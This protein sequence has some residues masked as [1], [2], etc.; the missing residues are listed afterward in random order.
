M[1]AIIFIIILLFFYYYFYFVSISATELI[2]LQL[3]IHEGIVL[4]FWVKLAAKV[5]K[6]L[7]R[8]AVVEYYSRLSRCHW[9]RRVSLVSL[10]N[11]FHAQRGLK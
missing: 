11:N 8:N 3:R 6:F 4:K 10:I 1:D 2:V 9:R 5:S 7:F